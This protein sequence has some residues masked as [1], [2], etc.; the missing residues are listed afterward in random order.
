M[1][2]KNI[3]F[4]GTPMFAACV[5]QGLID[6][7]YNV[8]SV[9]SQPDKPV[10]RKKVLMP[11]PV[12]EVALKHNIKVYQPVS[13]RKDYEFLKEMDIDLLITTAY[14]QFLPVEVLKLSKI[15]NINVHASLLPLLRGG[16]PIHRAIIE[17]HKQTGI[18]IMEMIDK[19]DAGRMYGKAVVEIDD[20]IN[21]S[22][23]FEKLAIVGR[24][25]LLETLPGIIDNTNKGEE[26]DEN[27][28]TFAYNI[29]REEEKI[30]FNLPTL[31]V[32]NLIRGLSETPGAHCFYN[33]KQF[34]IYKAKI[35]GYQNDDV[36][37]G[38]LKIIDK[39]RI[40]VKCS[41]GYLEL[42]TI[43]IEGKQKM[44]IK[45]FLNGINKEEF[46]KGLLK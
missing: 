46:V 44:D 24:D 19:M 38:T 27:E 43:Q 28:A 9:V 4:L 37:A 36:A 33:E 30:D 22:Q 35:Y 7:G 8:I 3:V 14:G 20:E 16:A 23:L 11:T 34:K 13:L 45:S 26:Q 31:N 21:T 32:H 29:K 25:L 6:N 41:D 18:T 40:I 15:N 5:L 2:S 42:L 39:N 12:K 17:G 10:G 1:K